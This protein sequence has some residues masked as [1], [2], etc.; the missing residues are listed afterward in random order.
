MWNAL[1]IALDLTTPGALDHV[2][3][4]VDTAVHE[5]GFPLCIKEFTP[6]YTGVNGSFRILSSLFVLVL[7]FSSAFFF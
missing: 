1:C 5:W 7:H 3:K 6:V 4:V 2:I